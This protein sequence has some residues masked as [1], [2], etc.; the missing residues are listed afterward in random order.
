[1]KDPGGPPRPSCI[2]DGDTS[3]GSPE[4][5][6]G[7]RWWKWSEDAAPVEAKAARGREAHIG[8]AQWP[9]TTQQSLSA[10]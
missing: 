7:T 8:W 1:M 10:S 4:D 6:L 3:A 2:A 9:P 5:A